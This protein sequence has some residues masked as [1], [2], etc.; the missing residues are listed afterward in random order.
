MARRACAVRAFVALLAGVVVSL[1]ALADCDT[2]GATPECDA[3]D[4][5]AT[6][7]AQPINTYHTDAG[8]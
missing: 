6:D 8:R 2:P 3:G 1:L 7:A 4:C 5:F